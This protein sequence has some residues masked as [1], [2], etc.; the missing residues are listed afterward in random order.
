MSNRPST[1]TGL[2]ALFS[3]SNLQERTVQ[4]IQ[5]ATNPPILSPAPAPLATEDFESMVGDLRRTFIGW[6]KKTELELSGERDTLERE[7]ALFK[8][9]K[10]KES[11]AIAQERQR[12]S[13]RIKDDRRR[14]EV[15][16]QSQLKQVQT[17][18]EEMRKRMSEERKKFESEIERDGVKLSL[19]R[20]ALDEDIR[21]FQIAKNIASDA[22]AA[23]ADIVELNIGGT[24][25][26]TV[27]KT[28]TDSLPAD[29]FLTQLVSGT[30]VAPRDR[31]GRIFFDRDGENFREILNFLRSTDK[32]PP[33]PRDAAATDSLLGESKFFGVNFF[34]FP[35]PF[36]IGGHDGTEPLRTCEVLDIGNQCWRG[37]RPMNTAR[38]YCGVGSGMHGGKIFAFGGQN[39]EYAALAETEI[40]DPMRDIWL[41]GGALQT[42]RRNCCGLGGLGDGRIFAIG[43]FDG[44]NIIGSVEALDL[45]IK[46][47]IELPPLITPRSSASAAILSDGRILVG[48]GTSGTRLKSVEIF[49]PKMNR[50]TKGVDLNETR[51]AG[52]MAA[53]GGKVFAVGGVDASQTVHSSCEMFQDDGDLAGSW[54]YRHSASVARIDAAAC[55]VEGTVLLAGGQDAGEI[56]RHVEFFQPAEDQWAE[57]PMLMFP[58]YGAAAVCVTL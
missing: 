27:K 22:K 10:E 21:K 34:P 44:E 15:E 39:L 32:I 51:S 49:D 40:Y 18:R 56:L 13:D 8:A 19:E 43:G 26:E 11:I 14:A 57:G 3:K 41:E 30:I 6:L 28:L 2:S 58:R 55:S 23:A 37:I 48:G 12:E 1:S 35:L 36:V 29:A 52:V 25:F 42:P 33:L 45:R 53:I 4:S 54:I 46:N 20:A 47:W 50:W 31:N 38:V 17:E 5:S 16:M 24:I 9:E 7:K